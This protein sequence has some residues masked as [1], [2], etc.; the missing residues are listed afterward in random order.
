MSAE[1]LDTSRWPE[2]Q[3]YLFL[4]GVRGAQ[5]ETSEPG[6]IGTRIRVQNTDGSTHVEE[7]IAWDPGRRIAVRFGEFQPQ[8]SRLATYFEETWDF[9]E[10]GEGTEVI[11]RMELHPKGMLGRVMLPWVAILMKK[12]FKRQMAVPR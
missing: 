11:R 6:M 3:G 1:F 9:R 10:T 8:L 5:I 2:F 4:P 7:I 12:A